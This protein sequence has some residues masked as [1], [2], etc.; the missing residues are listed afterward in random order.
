MAWQCSK[1]HTFSM[2]YYSIQKGEWCRKCFIERISLTLEECQRVAKERGGECL[3]T[4][5]RNVNIPMW[6]KCG[7]CGHEWPTKFSHIKN[8][9]WC[10]KCKVKKSMKTC[11]ERYGADNAMK[12]PELAMKSAKKQNNSYTLRHWF[13]QED[14]VCVGSWEKKVVEYFN[15][16]RIDYL[17]HPQTFTMPD[18]HTYTPD[19]YLPDRDMW[20]EIKG[21]MRPDAEENWKWFQSEYPNSELWDESVLGKKNIL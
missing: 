3:S 2:P 14:I 18:G 8:G 21:Y 1:G 9:T 15:N 10:P 12:V 7:D 5:Y 6:W 11:L 13:S 16:N 4:E 19:C 20:I 17:W